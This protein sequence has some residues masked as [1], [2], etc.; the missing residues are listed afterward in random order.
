MTSQ[1]HTDDSTPAA[2]ALHAVTVERDD[3]PDECTLYPRGASGVDRMSA[4]ITAEE[5]SFVDPRTVR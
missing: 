5:G 3:G 2:G 4:W 1:T